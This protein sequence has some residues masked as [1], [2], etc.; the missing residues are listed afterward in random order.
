MDQSHP[1]NTGSFFLRGISG[2][3]TD[4]LLTEWA[5]RSEKF[6][7][8]VLWEQQGLFDLLKD[9]KIPGR[10]RAPTWLRNGTVLAFGNPSFN[11]LLCPTSRSLAGKP[12]VLHVTRGVTALGRC[13]AESLPLK[14]HL[15]TKA[16]KTQDWKGVLLARVLQRGLQE[17]RDEC[18]R[19]YPFTPKLLKKHWGGV[20]DRVSKVGGKPLPPPAPVSQPDDD[21]SP[22]PA[23]APAPPRAWRPQVDRY[24]AKFGVRDVV[25]GQLVQDIASELSVCGSPGDNSSL[26]PE[27]A[28]DEESWWF[29]NWQR[30]RE[31]RSR[32]EEVRPFDET[33][34]ELYR[35]D[36]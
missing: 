17:V 6:T 25:A 33:T 27:V 10:S 11:T 24:P 14:K 28:C 13:S 20:I 21:P 35:S 22:R 23:P 5:L 8:H 32:G 34:P 29:K 30:E 9:E 2:G 36:H 19:D 15:T 18:C 26:L 31:K 12:A 1:L 16:F 7:Q 3:E 4:R